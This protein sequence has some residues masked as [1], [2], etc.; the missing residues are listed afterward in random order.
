MSVIVWLVELYLIL[1]L[2]RGGCWLIA[3]MIRSAI[4]AG[5]DQP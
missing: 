4:T 1:A 5:R 3:E 2:I